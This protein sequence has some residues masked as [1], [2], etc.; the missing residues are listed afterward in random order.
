MVGGGSGWSGRW[1]D[2]NREKTVTEERI[3]KLTSSS[4][5]EAKRDGRNERERR[6][7]H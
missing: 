6:D 1:F 3:S 2:R 5:G 4:I 7:E